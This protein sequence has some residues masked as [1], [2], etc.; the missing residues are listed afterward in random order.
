MKVVSEGSG[1]D[2][3]PFFLKHV[4]LRLVTQFHRVFKKRDGGLIGINE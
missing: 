4:G 1:K 3:I 2:K